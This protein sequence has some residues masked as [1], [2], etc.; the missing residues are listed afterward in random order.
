[1]PVRISVSSSESSVRTRPSGS[2]ACPIS[3]ACSASS[4]SVL[5]AGTRAG[6]GDVPRADHVAAGVPDLD[7]AGA[8]DQRG[9]RVV[10]PGALGVAVLVGGGGAVEDERRGRPAR[11]SEGRARW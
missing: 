2:C 5:C 1:M 4:S 6:V 9:E 7:A 8:G 11:C 3:S 10:V